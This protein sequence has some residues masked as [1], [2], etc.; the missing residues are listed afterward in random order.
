MKS[1]R[2]CQDRFPELVAWVLGELEPAAAKGLEEH[3]AGCDTCQKNYQI[4]QEEESEIR[5]G[6]EVLARN[7]GP[8]EPVRR[9]ELK[10]RHDSST[11]RAGTSDTP[12]LESVTTMVRA[13]KRLSAAAVFA[14]M[15][16]GVILCMLVSSA[17]GPA[18]ALEQTAQANQ[19]VTSYHTKVTPPPQPPVDGIREAWVELEPD[20]TPRMARIEVSNRDRGVR[21]ILVSK[22]RMEILVQ[23][24]NLHVV[25]D[26]KDLIAK[27]LKECMQFRPLFDPKL[28][29]EQLQADKAAGKVEVATQEPGQE[30]APILLTVTSNKT[31]DRREVYEIDPKTKLVVRV[32]EYRRQ[33]DTWGQLSQRDYLDYNQAIPPS[34]FQLEVPKDATTLD[35]AQM[36]TDKI[37]LSQ[38][39]LSDE[40]IA[41][42]VA[43]E[44]VEAMIA[45]DWQKAGRL[46]DGIPGEALQ[47]SFEQQHLKLLRI[48]EVGKP[49]KIE[50][51]RFTLPI[52]RV[53]MKVEIEQQGQKR[54]EDHPLRVYRVD[55]NS[56]RWSVH[57]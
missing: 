2:E 56:D 21:I 36:A 57:N 15:A 55:K 22:E 30:G 14:V 32:R 31:P 46:T 42:K 37:G 3:L 50:D 5:L 48:V 18:Y 4:L 8:V 29:F 20:G 23:G 16:A 6:F 25:S 19:H 49:T 47:K 40:E 39:Q 38:G 28:A 43:R 26:N 35:P 53:P 33:G 9:E 27:G 44:C 11:I 34:V 7:L 24:T 12:L 13:H 1:A 54:I 10:P 17:S 45:G 51:P 41:V 52:L